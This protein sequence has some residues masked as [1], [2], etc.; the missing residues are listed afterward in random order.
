MPCEVSPRAVP[1]GD[2]GLNLKIRL[3]GGEGGGKDACEK[4]SQGTEST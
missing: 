2:Y 4:S 3:V 1:G